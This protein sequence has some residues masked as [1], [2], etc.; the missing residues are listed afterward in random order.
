MLRYRP[1]V[2]PQKIENKPDP[3]LA[4]R[5]KWSHPDLSGTH[6][7]PD[8]A[9]YDRTI[10]K[11]YYSAQ[12]SDG[13]DSL[14]FAVGDSKL[15]QKWK[16]DWIQRQYAAGHTEKRPIIAANGGVVRKTHKVTTER[17]HPL[18]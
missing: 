7:N 9:V 1:T 17:L 3:T 12:E 4:A 11:K 8:W 6:L 10:K 5:F 18:E 14:V 16:S 13:K 15:S 2:G